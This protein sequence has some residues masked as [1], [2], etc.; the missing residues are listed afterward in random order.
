[1]SNSAPRESHRSEVV[2]PEPV[3]A[4]AGL[5]GVDPPAP[6][7]GLPLLWHWLFTL[8]RPAQT[9]LGLD[10][11]PLLTGTPG[12]PEPGRRRMWAG[13]RVRSV[14]PLR[15]GELATRRTSVLSTVDKQG[16]SGRLTLVTVSHRIYQRGELAVDEQQDLVYREAVAGGALRAPIDQALPAAAPGPEDWAIDTSTT[17][18][19]RFSALT[20]N[21]HRIHYDRDYAREVEGYPGLLVHGPLQALAMAEAARQRGLDTGPGVRFDYRLVAPL[22]E[23]DGMVVTAQSSATSATATVRR[24]DGYQTA[25]GTL[26]RE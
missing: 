11:H 4:L 13:G 10:S 17:L 20:Y 5:L 24:A 1:V 7:A 22:F 18:L 12:L 14:A 16:R 2:Q 3:Q 25:I 6:A 26:H 21:G 15:C 9:D 8:E 23:H 19:L